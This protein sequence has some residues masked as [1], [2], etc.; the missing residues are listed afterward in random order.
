MTMTWYERAALAVMEGRNRRRRRNR[1]PG[2]YSE[3]GNTLRAALGY[4]PQDAA[5]YDFQSAEMF[6]RNSADAG[7][8]YA[9]PM[10]EKVTYPAPPAKWRRNA[11]D[12]LTQ[13][14]GFVPEYD[15]TGTN[16]GLSVE[17]QRTGLLKDAA[18]CS[19]F[20]G[21][22]WTT[23]GVSSGNVTAVSSAFA[24]KTA[25]S[26]TGDG[27]GGRFIGQVF[28]AATSTVHALTAIV[29][30]GSATTFDLGLYDITA[31]G[32]LALGRFT[33]SSLTGYTVAG[34]VAGWSIVSHGIGPNGGRLYSVT[35]YVSTGANSSVRTYYYPF[36][37]NASTATSIIHYRQA[38][39]TVL[40]VGSPIVTDAAQVTRAADVISQ[41]LSALPDISGGF[42]ARL[43]FRRP[44]QPTTSVYPRL[45]SF[46]DGTANNWI[47]LWMAGA[48]NV[49]AAV[50]AGGVVHFTERAVSP[51]GLPP[52]TGRN[53]LA[54]SVDVAGGFR[55]S[56]NG[57][58]PAVAGATP[59]MP[60]MT[61]FNVGSSYAGDLVANSL[62]ESLVVLPGVL[63]DA[64]IQK[65][66]A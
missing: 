48:T 34:T 13:S 20:A 40:D 19:P 16:V 65:L 46:S 18:N 39:A 57:A 44:I 52:G 53:V 55:S 5:L 59:T 26:V 17:E 49:R 62:F 33:W 64:E 32:W 23:G 58:A 15:A 3:L 11:S 31:A 41:A 1:V 36:S 38:E 60:S 21:T 10:A 25:Y 9:G 43:A 2:Q 24:G 45:L 37:Q 12:L 47:E 7:L 61:K 30:E 27:V 4:D 50:V 6:V 51:A 63:S 22:A 14:S 56:W 28:A 29:E 8:E 35:M 66:A 54:F 42:T